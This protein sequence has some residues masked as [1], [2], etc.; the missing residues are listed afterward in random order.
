MST[1]PR[2]LQGPET[3]EEVSKND[4]GMPGVQEEVKE[5]RVLG[6]KGL[7]PASVRKRTLRSLRVMHD[8]RVRGGQQAEAARGKRI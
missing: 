3:Q 7:T 2:H 5:S 1:P 6:A 4:T 8:V